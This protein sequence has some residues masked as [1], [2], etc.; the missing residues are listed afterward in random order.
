MT[1]KEIMDYEQREQDR[2]E[3]YSEGLD[4]FNRDLHIS[5][6]P[7]GLG[8]RKHNAWRDGWLDGELALNQS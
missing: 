3:A 1:M 6:N 4:A 8:G 2:N 7:Y 5:D